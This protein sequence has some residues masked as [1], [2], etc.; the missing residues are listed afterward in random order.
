MRTPFLRGL[1]PTLALVTVACGS[2]TGADTPT[3]LTGAWGA[4]GAV[5]GGGTAGFTLVLTQSG[6]TTTGTA[7]YSAGNKTFT[8]SGTVTGHTWTFQ[9]TEPAPCAGTYTGTATVGANMQGS[10]GGSDC[11]G[12]VSMTFTASRQQ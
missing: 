12:N 11:S 6:T 4:L 8:V 5:S 2:A 1:I 7:A 10:L 3:D 9:M